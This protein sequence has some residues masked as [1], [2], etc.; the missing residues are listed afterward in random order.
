MVASPLCGRRR[1][2]RQTGR[3]VYPPS[4]RAPGGR[5]SELEGRTAVAVL[6]LLERYDRLDAG[7]TRG[8][9]RQG[10]CPQ[11]SGKREAPAPC[12]GGAARGDRALGQRRSSRSPTSL[13]SRQA[14]R[15]PRPPPGGE[16]AA[17]AEVRHGHRRDRQPAADHCRTATSSTSPAAGSTARGTSS[18][19][20]GSTILVAEGWATGATGY[21]ITGDAAVVAFGSGNLKAAAV[22]LRKQHPDARIIVLADDDW[23]KPGNPGL[24]TATAA[25]SA[26]NALLAV[27][28]FGGLDPGRQGHRLQR[29][30]PARRRRRRQG[31]D[32]DRQLP[33][34]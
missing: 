24:T 3:R 23:K 17:R 13:P 34:E 12:R 15:S 27:P 21:E 30:A 1:A 5:L 9:R 2:S 16:R 22:E 28:Q 20:P 29:P 25:A 7:G 4:R 31:R 32:R 11:E 33:T 6:A 14:G 18:A 26:A 19:K 8:V 10:C